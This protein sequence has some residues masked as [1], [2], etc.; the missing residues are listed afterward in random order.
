MKS[1]KWIIDI[2]WSDNHFNA[3]SLNWVSFKVVLIPQM[4]QEVLFIFVTLREKTTLIRWN[5]I[6]IVYNIRRSTFLVLFY[7]RLFSVQMAE[8]GFTEDERVFW[9]AEVLGVGG[10]EEGDEGA[11]GLL[12][13]VYFL[14][15]VGR[16]FQFLHSH[17]HCDKVSPLALIFHLYIVFG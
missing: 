11:F 6:K 14:Y 4:G 17:F 2:A 15:V 10:V 16:Q 13:F 9:L 7:L 8:V 5:S 1:I 3:S 12:Y